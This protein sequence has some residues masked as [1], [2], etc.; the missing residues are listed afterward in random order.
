MIRVAVIG[1]GV[2]GSRHAQA[3]ARLKRGCEVYLVDP[4]PDAGKAAARLLMQDC[5]EAGAIKLQVL[6]ALG[7]LPGTLD[8]AVVATTAQL[9][10]QVIEQ[11]LGHATVRYLV[12]EKFLFQ[13]PDDYEAVGAILRRA[14][15]RAWVNCP[16]R[17]WPGYQDLRRIISGPVALQVATHA[18]YGI[19][20]S[21]IHLLDVLSYLSGDDDFHL[22]AAAVDAA[23]VPHRSGGVELTGTLSGH[24]RRGSFFRFAAYADGSLP[25]LTI[26]DSPHLRAII[27][28]GRQHARVSRAEE[29]WAW[30]DQPFGVLS[31]SQ[32]TDTVVASLIDDGTCVLPEFDESS[33]LHLA[34]LNPLLRHYRNAV[35]PRA[36]GC[37]IT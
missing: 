20:T 13:R 35:D 2:I 25:P 36:E 31:Q 19:G 30:R 7:D 34:I 11:L 5:V 24:S 33:R 37:P 21:A 6:S 26:I 32:L 16:R 4:S 17:M 12:L 15:A 10:R 3:L 14:G 18:R 1:C 8:V 22:S 23:P 9:R 27:D 29:N 28:E